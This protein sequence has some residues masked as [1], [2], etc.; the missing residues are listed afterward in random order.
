MRILQPVIWAKGAFLAPQHLQ[1]Q[2]R[3][4]ESVL[5][6]RLE[7]LN[8]R[9]WGFTS[10]QVDQEALAAG[11]FALHEASG[12]MPD[13]LPFEIPL[14]D[15][16][17]PAKP[18]AEYY[19]PD[20]RSL[21]VFLSIPSYRPAG[22]NVSTADR[23]SDTR[24]VAVVRTMR[25]DTTG[26]TE[27]PVQMARKNFQLLAEGDPLRGRTTLRVARVLKNGD[28][29]DLD[30]RFAPPLL[31]WSASPSL[32]S[33]VRRLIEILSAKSGMLAGMRRQKNQSLAEFTVSDI[34]N[35]WLLYSVNAH[36]PT[37]RHLYETRFGH[38]EE[39]Y[40]LLLSLSSVLTTFSLEILPRDLPAYDHEELGECFAELEKKLLHLL[41]TV[42][43]SNFISLP[44]KLVRPSIYGASLDEDKYLKGTRMFL[45]ASANVD[46]A[47]LIAKG[48]HLIKVCSANH[49][50]H[51]VK[52]AL[53]G[54]T[55]THQVSPPSSIPLRL[56]HQYFSLSQSG[57]AWEA[58]VR[59]RNIAA[60]VPGD[61]PEPQLEL[62][63]LLPA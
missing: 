42:V 31:R 20:Q 32:V 55:L 60:Y 57:L 39:L 63:I 51:L 13:G 14:A 30:P 29:Y 40:S 38:P 19:G 22:V 58:I 53:P 36:L 23:A 52:Q 6:F 9:P 49:I 10:L 48:P 35:F 37:L 62:I 27:K 33:I 28:S 4:A 7:A 41:E 3:F 11:R 1:A 12:L 5:Q 54:V 44:L 18:L 2:D 17:P 26:L 34:A 16:A 46:E 56:N 45:A 50:E 24:Y 15:E 59:S 61:F 47:E 25:D 21:D 8:F 43:P